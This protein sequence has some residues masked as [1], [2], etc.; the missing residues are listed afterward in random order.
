MRVSLAL[1]AV[2]LA[3][4]ASPPACAQ[5]PVPPACDV[6]EATL[7]G[8]AEAQASRRCTSRALVEATLARIEALDRS[9][10]TLRSVLE[11]NPDALAI[12][13]ALDRERAA[14]RVR[15]PLHGVPVLLKGNVGTADRMATTAGARALAGVIAPADAFIVTRLRE[16][17]AVVVGKANLSEWANFRAARSSSGWSGLG[18]QTRNPYVLD[19]SPCGSSSGTG[20][21]IAASLGAV[22]VGTETDGSIV[23]PSS[24]SGLVGVKPTVGLVSRTGI[25]PLSSSQDTAG[26]M[27]RTV[28][29]AAVLLG[30]LAGVDP[31]DAATAASAGRSHADY[32]QF[33]DTD[34]LRGARIGVLREG[35]FF[36]YSPPADRL[37]DAAIDAMRMAG[38]TIVDSLALPGGYDDDEF[39]VLLYDFKHDVDAYLASLGA[40]SSVRSLADVI[41]FN[42]AHPDP[43]GVGQ[44]LLVMAQAKGPLTDSVYVAALARSRRIAR[45][46]LDSLLA[47]HR[48]DALVA[49][50][51]SPM[52]PIDV[53]NGDHFLGSSSTPAA[54]SGYPSVTV[55]AGL[56]GGLPVGI[57]LVGPAW[58]EPT[59]LRLAYAYEQ[60]TRMRR[61]PQFLP[62]L[63]LPAGH[64]PAGQ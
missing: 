35:S 1:S 62:T 20:T 39:T 11:L 43:D 29:D 22:G 8:L 5:A 34:G 38:A 28:R 18:G 57:S 55:P 16:A 54:V 17:G 50:T 7:A 44:E 59:L 19:R 37:T 41:A 49:P 31:A 46:G 47:A 63:P 53:L 64:P 6:V 10:P 51:G 2:A 27:A 33:L 40:R 23:C 42:E 60:A 48:L 4:F 56:V 13:D 24:A 3:A 25:I 21:G 12:A 32:T 61:P 14:G 58:S 52:W 9:G 26:P 30:I 15:G 36:G 45:T